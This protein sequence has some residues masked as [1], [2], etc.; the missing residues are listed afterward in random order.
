MAENFLEINSC[1]FSIIPF[2]ICSKNF[3][4]RKPE[5]TPLSPLPL[6]KEETGI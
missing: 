6:I 1:H 4:L 3:L 5:F 2:N